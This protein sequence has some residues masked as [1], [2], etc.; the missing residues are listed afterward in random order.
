ML[1]GLKVKAI[2]R[3]YKKEEK[4]VR[5]LHIDQDLYEK[6][7]YLSDNVFDA[8][9]S[10]IINVCIENSLIKG[11][12]IKYYKRPANVDSVYRSIVLRKS[13]CD[14][15]LKIR[16]KTGISFSRLVNSCIKE[17]LEDYKNEINI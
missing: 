15:I 16:E 11:K 4:I 7:Q 13:F 2:D 5:T 12:E 8:S 14:E 10:K 1:G 6:I 17:F 9:A 3:L